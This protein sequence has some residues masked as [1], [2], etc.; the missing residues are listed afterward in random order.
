MSDLKYKNPEELQTVID[1]CSKQ[2]GVFQG[3]INNLQTKK[4]WAAKYLREKTPCPMTMEEIEFQ[5]GYKVTLK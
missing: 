3:K 5:L 1:D 4:Q 2:M